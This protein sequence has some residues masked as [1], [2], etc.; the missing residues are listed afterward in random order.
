MTEAVHVAKLREQAERQQFEAFMKRHT[1]KLLDF[2][3]PY[4]GRLIPEQREEFLTVALERAWESRHELKPKKTAFG[5]EQVE[6]LRWWEDY[7]LKPAARS[8]KVWTLRTWDRQR[9]FVKGTKLGRQ[10]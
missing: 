3:K 1:A 4:I 9:E 8:R 7:C 5:T 6:L 10:D 2:A